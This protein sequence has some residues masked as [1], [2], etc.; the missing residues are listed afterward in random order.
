[1]SNMQ[2]V[3]D[4]RKATSKVLFMQIK[5]PMNGTCCLACRFHDA[6]IALYQSQ[7]DCTVN[8]IRHSR[9]SNLLN[10]QRFGGVLNYLT[11]IN[12]FVLAGKS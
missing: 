10:I 7:F 6:V 12:A 9:K 5:F 2:N 3:A 11:P 1:M 4:C 8:C